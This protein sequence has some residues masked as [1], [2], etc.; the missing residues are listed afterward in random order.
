MWADETE[1][2]T[3]T[4]TS[5]GRRRMAGRGGADDS[6]CSGWS[7]VRAPE[8]RRLV[9]VSLPGHRRPRRRA[10]AAVRRFG[11]DRNLWT[12]ECHA[13]TCAAECLRLWAYPAETAGRRVASNPQGA[14]WPCSAIPLTLP[15]HCAQPARGGG[16]GSRSH[17][18]PAPDQSRRCSST[19]M[20]P[21]RQMFDGA[22]C[23]AQAVIQKVH[24]RDFL[25]D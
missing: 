21:M 7:T 9:R 11:D 20:T 6:D 16:E 18:S 12:R 1:T 19:R 24:F 14:P 8:H 23:L 3:Q 13:H 15:P 10:N 22:E 25:N 2:R 17:C 5:I 4:C